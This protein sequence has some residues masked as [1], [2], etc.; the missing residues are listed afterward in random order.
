LASLFLNIE[1]SAVDKK[2][3]RTVG[4]RDLTDAMRIIASGMQPET[5]TS[6]KTPMQVMR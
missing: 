2:T 1:E 5:K 4:A 6:N 3:M